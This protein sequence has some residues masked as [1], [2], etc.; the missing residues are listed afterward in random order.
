MQVLFSLAESFPCSDPNRGFCIHISPVGGNSARQLLKGKGLP[1]RLQARQGLCGA[2]C[3]RLFLDQDRANAVYFVLRDADRKEITGRLFG[4]GLPLECFERIPEGNKII[5]IK[6]RLAVP[7]S[8]E[9]KARKLVIMDQIGFIHAE[10][11]VQEKGHRAR[12]VGSARTVHVDRV[13]LPGRRARKIHFCS[14]A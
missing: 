8:V 12:A 7:Y 6:A 4:K 2:A 1:D 14:S 10:Q 5:R 3:G 11:R 13:V 9:G